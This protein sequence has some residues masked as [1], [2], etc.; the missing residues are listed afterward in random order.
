MRGV[1]QRNWIVMSPMAWVG[2]PG[3]VRSETADAYHLRRAGIG[4]GVITL[5]SKARPNSMSESRPAN[6]ILPGRVTR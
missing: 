6:S 2:W 5:Q 4:G 3:G 1:T